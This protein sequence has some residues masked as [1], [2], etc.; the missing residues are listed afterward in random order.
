MRSI[1]RHR[2]M[3]SLVARAHFLIRLLR[4]R[5]PETALTTVAA[6]RTVPGDCNL[7]DAS[8]SNT[9]KL[10]RAV[11]EFCVGRAFRSSP[12]FVCR[13]RNADVGGNFSDSQRL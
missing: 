6:S 9:T 5:E 12:L 8:P 1:I 10:P 3:A 4:M 2:V 13:L 7:A 11:S